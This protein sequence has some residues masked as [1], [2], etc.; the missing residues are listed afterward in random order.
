M[1]STTTTTTRD[2]ARER[3]DDTTL[4]PTAVIH[5]SRFI[6]TPFTEYSSLEAPFTTR[7]VGDWT[8]SSQAPE[9]VRIAF[10]FF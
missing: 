3:F 10:F 1:A 7:R 9:R 4:T 6:A 2:D 5:V 8:H